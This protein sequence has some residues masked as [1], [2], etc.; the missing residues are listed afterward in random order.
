[1]L[2]HLHFNLRVTGA[3]PL[4]LAFFRSLLLPLR[5]IKRIRMMRDRIVC[6]IGFGA[7][8]GDSGGGL[9][10]IPDTATLWAEGF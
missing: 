8:G 1:V 10:C 4:L 7:G 3:S 6:G 5:N 2:L 9:L